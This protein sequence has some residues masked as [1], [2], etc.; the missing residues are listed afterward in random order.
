[1]YVL[2]HNN[3][4]N[5]QESTLQLRSPDSTEAPYVLPSPAPCLPSS[6]TIRSPFIL[7]SALFQRVI[8]TDRYAYLGSEARNGLEAPSAG[9]MCRKQLVVF[10]HK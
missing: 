8:A 9:F 6:T 4:T 3:R 7:S 2:K 1:M 10:F 5:T